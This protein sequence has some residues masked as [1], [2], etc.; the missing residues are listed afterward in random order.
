[1]LQQ[2]T[3]KA[4]V[5]FLERFFERFPKIEELAAADEQDVLRTWHGLGYYS[6]ARNLQAAAKI[7]KSSTPKSNKGKLVS[8]GL[9]ALSAVDYFLVPCDKQPGFVFV[10]PGSVSTLEAAC[11]QLPL[12]APIAW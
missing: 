4:V 9:C 2:T 7:M 5:P 6:R 8:L 12:Y 3:I 10:S 1:M 11:L